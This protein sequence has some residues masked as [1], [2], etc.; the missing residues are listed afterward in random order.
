MALAGTGRPV[1]MPLPEVDAATKLWS[2]RNNQW[3]LRA[4][5]ATKPTG[6]YRHNAAAML[7]LGRIRVYE[8]GPLDR[9]RFTADPNATI[10]VLGQPEKVAS[11]HTQG[12]GEKKRI[13][14]LLESCGVDMQIMFYADAVSG[15]PSYSY[16][17]MGGAKY[18][19]LCVRMII[20]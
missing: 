18:P 19:I 13:V 2:K 15:S 8:M 16:S 7:Y 5:A 6:R 12:R 4:A 17:V 11:I 3:L 1:V 20:V 10:S 9:D 14:A